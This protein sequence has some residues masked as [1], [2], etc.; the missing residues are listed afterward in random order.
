MEGMIAI[1]QRD[2][3][4]FFKDRARLFGSMTMPILLLIVFGVGMGGSMESLMQNVAGGDLD[5]NY[6]AFI[7]PGIV[8]MTLLM[9]SVFSSLSIIQDRDFG[10]M[11]EILVSPVSRVSIALGKMLGSATVAVMQGLLLFLLMPVLGVTIDLVSFFVLLPVMFLLACAFASLGLLI[12]SVISSTQ[13]FQL[14]V[15][16]IVMPMIFLSG[17]L[18]PLNNMPAWID[19]LVTLN[20]V[21][22]GV[23]LMKHIMI[24]VDQLS[25]EVYVEMGLDLDFFGIPVT[26]LGEVLFIIG[27]TAVLIV[28]ATLSFS[29]ANR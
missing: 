22:Y 7:F 20:P 23:D 12:A 3:M 29:R 5:F 24:D 26:P 8:S 11:R 16:A 17:A 25:R 14:V 18:F 19:V 13:A 6:V 1:W 15:N 28:L 10:Y 4:K 9:T 2:V 27:F 21:T